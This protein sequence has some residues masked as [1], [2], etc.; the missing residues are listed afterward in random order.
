M[1]ASSQDLRTIRMPQLSADNVHNSDLLFDLP[2]AAAWL[3]YWRLELVVS[4]LLLWIA[5][6]YLGFSLSTAGDDWVALT[7]DSLLI[8]YALQAGRWLHAVLMIVQ[9]HSRVAPTFSIAVLL[10]AI[11]TTMAMFAAALKLRRAGSVVLFILLAGCFPFWAEFTSFRILHLPGAVALIFSAAYGYIGWRVAASWGLTSLSR[12]IVWLIL[13]GIAF[14]LCAATYQGFL[15]VGVMLMSCYLL[16][17][18]DR[19]TSRV[20]AARLCLVA[21][22]MFGLGV[23]FYSFQVMLARVVTGVESSPDPTYQLANSLVSNLGELRLTLGRLGTYLWAFFTQPNHLF[24]LWPKLLFAGVLLAFVLRGLVS[25]DSVPKQNRLWFLVALGVLVLAPWA[26]GLIRVPDPYR[27]NAIVSAGL[28]YAVVLCLTLEGM[29]SVPGRTLVA[30][31]GTAIVVCFIFIQNSAALITQ[32]NNQRDLAVVNR[33]LDHL[34]AAEGYAQ[35]SRHAPVNVVLSGNF[36]LPKQRPF[37]STAASS[38][39]NSSIIECDILSCQSARLDWAVPLVSSDA[40]R[41]RFAEYV[42]QNEPYQ[43]TLKPIIAELPFWPVPGSV[44]IIDD[45]TVVVRLPETTSGTQHPSTDA[46]VAL[47][48][49]TASGD[50][51]VR[52][53]NGVGAFS[54]AVSNLGEQATYRL[55]ATPSHKLTTTGIAICQTEPGTGVCLDAPTRSGITLT[56]ASHQDATFAV[57]A[58][59]GTLTEQDVLN[60]RIIV[61]IEDEGGAVHAATSVAIAGPS[62]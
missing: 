52:L 59:D 51:F 30:T 19:D 7:D 36:Q 13:G 6:G 3:K 60:N 54:V 41:Y 18:P 2:G 25:K 10:L 29:R 42:K 22:V 12:R 49:I 39:L 33:L 47:L 11:A 9:D 16:G 56:L 27:Y 31:V 45:T 34:S 37:V 48:P 55:T 8:K 28:L 53:S 32:Q 57:Y 15:P 40:V 21:V 23:L 24:P 35:L 38:V 5:Y 43:L 62:G 58:S 50:G 61:R 14:S 1:L 4:M 44:R 26:L 17:E 46:R 20:S